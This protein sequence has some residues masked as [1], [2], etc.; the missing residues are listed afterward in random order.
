MTKI[1]EDEIAAVINKHSQENL[2]NTPDFI[3]ACYLMDC[4]NAFDTAVNRRE[5]W[6]GRK[7]S[8]A[9]EAIVAI[10]AD[11]DAAIGAAKLI[12]QEALDS[13]EARQ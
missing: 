3:L 1:F 8:E 6:Y 13:D 9:L 7:T 10:E 11:S 12:A 4:M 2:S 5:E